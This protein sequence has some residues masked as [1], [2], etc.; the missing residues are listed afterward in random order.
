MDQIN[1]RPHCRAALTTKRALENYLH[2]AAIAAA[3]GRRIEIT[4]D[5]PVAETLAQTQPE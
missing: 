4:D 3:F 1:A 2:P 5:L